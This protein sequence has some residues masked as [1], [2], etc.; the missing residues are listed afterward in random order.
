MGSAAQLLARAV[1]WFAR[2][3][4]ACAQQRLQ[5]GGV[6]SVLVFDLRVE[7][8]SSEPVAL[9]AFVNAVFASSGMAFGV[10]CLCTVSL[11]LAVRGAVHAPS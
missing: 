1:C 8:R 4:M 5:C 2:Q 9:L 3:N 11:S 6:L 7:S 10:F